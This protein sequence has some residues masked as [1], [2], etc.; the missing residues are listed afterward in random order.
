MNKIILSKEQQLKILEYFMKT[1][2]P[3]MLKESDK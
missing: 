3:K 1:S 2:V